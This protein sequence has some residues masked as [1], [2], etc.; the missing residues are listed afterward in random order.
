[1]GISE[2]VWGFVI[3]SMLQPV[4]RKKTI[5]RFRHQ[6]RTGT[7]P[8]NKKI[9]NFRYLEPGTRPEN[10]KISQISVI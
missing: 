2:I 1:M 5:S 10:K 4:L 3:V 6:S 8:E 7:R 9:P